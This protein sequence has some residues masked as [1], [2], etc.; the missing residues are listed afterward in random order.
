V[1]K[2][3]FF[4]FIHSPIHWS[5]RWKQIEFQLYFP[6]E[7]TSDLCSLNYCDI[8]GYI[9]ATCIWNIEIDV[10]WLFRV[11]GSM[12]EVFISEVSRSPSLSHVEQELIT[13]RRTLFYAGCDP[14]CTH[15]KFCF[16]W[17]WLLFYCVSALSSLLTM[18]L[19]FCINIH[20]RSF[21]KCWYVLPNLLIRKCYILDIAVNQPVLL[22]LSRDMYHSVETA[23]VT[24]VMNNKAKY[25]IM[26]QFLPC[27]NF[28]KSI[29][30]KLIDSSLIY[31]LLSLRI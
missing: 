22:H 4:R 21:I 9:H 20:V 2:T 31:N 11:N 15:I 26:F 6:A 30:S 14:C 16:W 25:K 8:P 3:L 1:S 18:C 7:S 5:W 19:S 10:H 27:V 28:F 24:V 29:Y 12:I 17:R 13:I 23:I